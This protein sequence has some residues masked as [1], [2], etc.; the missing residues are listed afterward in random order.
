MLG[1]VGA[2]AKMSGPQKKQKSDADAALERE[3]R[4]GRK[5]TLEE[6]IGRL[7]GPGGMKGES[8][9]ARMQQAEL[10]IEE[11]LRSH[12]ADAGGVLAVVLHRAVKGSDLLLNNYEQPLVVLASCCQRA[13]GSESLLQ[14]IVR[15]ADTEWGRMMGERPYFNKPGSPSHPDDPYTIESVRRNL[16]DLLNQLSAELNDRTT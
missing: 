16:A 13:L 2:W 11:W 8:P 3:I 10:E 14:E 15:A 12:L 1:E 9:I 6:A 4:E 7:A 5:F